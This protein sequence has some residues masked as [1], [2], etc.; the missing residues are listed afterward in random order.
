MLHKQEAKHLTAFVRGHEG[1]FVVV[2]IWISYLA[3]ARGENNLC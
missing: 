2:V 3:G 1:F